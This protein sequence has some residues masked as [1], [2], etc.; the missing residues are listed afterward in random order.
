VPKTDAQKFSVKAK[1]QKVLMGGAYDS[2]KWE[3]P[4]IVLSALNAGMFVGDAS[5]PVVDS[6]SFVHLVLRT[7]KDL[8]RTGPMCMYRNFS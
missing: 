3:L 4:S 2:E 1:V 5:R 7:T 6:P 8:R